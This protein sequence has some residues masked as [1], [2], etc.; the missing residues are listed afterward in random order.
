MFASILRNHADRYPEMQIHDIYKLVH[1]AAMGSEH[2][3]MDRTRIL[4]VLIQEMEEISSVPFEEPL[5][6]P[7]SPDG[8][9][10]RVHLRPFAE[11]KKDASILADAFH[12][13][14]SEFE[15]RID[16][17]ESHWKSATQTKLFPN[18]LMDEFISEMKRQNYPAV[19]HSDA[20]RQAYKPAYR[21]VWRKFFPF[22]QTGG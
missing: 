19:N 5:A 15:G 14:A 7:I 21:V 1:Q 8:E 20:Y 22:N 9:I 17:I 2:A 13:T 3:V 16:M 6:D 10:I 11:T 12:R 18:H 4:E